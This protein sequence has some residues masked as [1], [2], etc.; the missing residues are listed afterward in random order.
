MSSST[1]QFLADPPGQLG[2]FL[3]AAYF[4]RHV[5]VKYIYDPRVIVEFCSENY[6]T[7]YANNW[8][9]SFGIN[10]Q[11]AVLAWTGDLMS[12]PEAEQIHWQ[13]ENIAPQNN[14]ASDFYDGQIKAE[15][16]EPPLGV[17]VLNAISKWNVEFRARYGHSL[18]KSRDFEERLEEVQRYR[19]LIINRKDDFAG[20]I[21][22]LNEIINENT[23]NDDLKRLL[24]NRNIDIITGTKGNKLIELVYKDVHGDNDNLIAP[25]FYL[26]DLRLWADH[27]M[28][29]EKLREVAGSLD[30][31]DLG[32]FEGIMTALLKRLLT[33]AETLSARYG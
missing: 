24:R 20:Y 21:S 12:L 31:S 15:F 8:I 23:D 19:N 10:S 22:G 13:S 9:L 28:G 6:G 14:T 29:D 2:G 7:I 1:M 17:Q 18:Y 4:D 27:N 32:N 26:Y 11:G 25:F 5:M 33:S 3:R 30:V 16:T